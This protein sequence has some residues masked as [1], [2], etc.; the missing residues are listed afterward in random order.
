MPRKKGTAK[1][2]GRKVGTP[3]KVTAEL[4]DRMKAFLEGHFDVIEKEFR[5][6]TPERQIVLF[7]RYLKFVLPQLQSTSVDL[8]I[9]DMTDKELSMLLK[10]L[11]IHS[12][13]DKR[14]P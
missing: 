3:N 9:E 11:S 5:A 10:K 13:N 12:T 6:L 4:R 14:N 2:G 7:E 1:T 8:S